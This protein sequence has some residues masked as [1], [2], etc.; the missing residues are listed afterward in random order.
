ML[1]RPTRND[2]TQNLGK[3]NQVLGMVENAGISTTRDSSDVS[4]YGLSAAI[5]TLNAAMDT[6]RQVEYWC[7]G[8]SKGA[9]PKL[10]AVAR[11]I[12]AAIEK[13]INV[14]DRLR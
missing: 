3:L 6:L 14:I 13:Y 11:P 8:R 2:A 7:P 4:Y 10:E 12:A 9:I 1:Q 5:E